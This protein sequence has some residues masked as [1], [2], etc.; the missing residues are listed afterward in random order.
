AER[1]HDFAWA[2]GP[3]L[4]AERS[5]CGPT[6]LYLL[7]PPSARPEAARARFVACEGLRRLGARYGAH[8]YPR[9]TIILPAEGAAGAAGMEYPTLFPSTSEP[10]LMPGVRWASVEDTTAHE[11]AHQWFQ[12]LV[13]TDEVR[14]PMLDEGVSSWVTNELVG[15]LF[16]HERTFSE[17]PAI[18]ALEVLR[19]FV[20]A[21]NDPPPASH[22]E[23][24]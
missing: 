1:V 2:A 21:P 7:H 19:A 15:E 24:F 18:D 12:G 8:P 10:P 3:G 13:A 6:E 22:V 20:W 17:R 14:W 4:E 23:D 16:G 5:A 9:L 11:L